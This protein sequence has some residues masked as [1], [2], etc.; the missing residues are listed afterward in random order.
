MP[1]QLSV[2]V[3]KRTQKT[4]EPTTN[5][6]A[7]TT[8][9]FFDM[10]SSSSTTTTTSSSTSSSSSS[11]IINKKNNNNA[12]KKELDLIALRKLRH[13]NTQNAARLLRMMELSTKHLLALHKRMDK[14]AIAIEGK[15]YKEDHNLP[16]SR[17]GA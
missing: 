11:S 5:N 10:P 9:Y 6:K 15:E 8:T 13:D 1:L 16:S 4:A 14:E 2:W 12:T 3:Y 7:T 17:S